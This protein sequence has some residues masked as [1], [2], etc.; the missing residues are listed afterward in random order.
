MVVG[1]FAIADIPNP[2]K[3]LLTGQSLGK[4]PIV[5]AAL[6]VD[7]IGIHRQFPA[8]IYVFAP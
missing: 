3:G 2:N 4:H 8:F 1:S 6:L 7:K 5:V